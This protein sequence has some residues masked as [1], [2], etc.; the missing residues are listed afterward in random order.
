MI[1]GSEASPSTVPPSLPIPPTPTPSMT[2]AEGGWVGGD[3]VVDYAITVRLEEVEE[4]VSVLEHVYQTRKLWE[5]SIEAKM[6][7]KREWKDGQDGQPRMH[8]LGEEGVG[9]KEGAL[10]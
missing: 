7:E 5:N 4:S 8:E 6:V 9:N 1:S 2:V 10:K 3:T